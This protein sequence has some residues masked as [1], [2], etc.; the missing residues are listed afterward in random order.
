MKNKNSWVHKFKKASSQNTMVIDGFAKL[1]KRLTGKNSC[2]FIAIEIEINSADWKV[3]DV[4]CTLLPFVEK[5]ILCQACDA[6][7]CYKKVAGVRS[8]HCS[9]DFTATN[10]ALAGADLKYLWRTRPLV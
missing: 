3:L 5:E 10:Q 9:V 1:P 4:Y 8:R 2:S 7:R 6:Y